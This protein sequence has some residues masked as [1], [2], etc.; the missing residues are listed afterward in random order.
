MNH[1][2]QFSPQSLQRWLT[3]P[4]YDLKLPIWANTTEFCPHGPRRASQDPQLLAWLPDQSLEVSLELYDWNSMTF[5]LFLETVEPVAVESEG[6]G[7]FSFV[8]Q[9]LIF[10]A[11]ARWCFSWAQ[12]CGLDG[13]FPGSAHT[14]PFGKAAAGQGS[15]AG[16]EAKKAGPGFHRQLLYLQFQKRCLFNYLELL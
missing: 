4:C 6:S 3:L 15:A 10:P 16:K 1:C 5:T 12:D 2:I 9:Q 14:E 8:W 11:E 7:I 13:S